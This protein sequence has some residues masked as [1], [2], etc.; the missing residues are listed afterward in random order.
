LTTGGIVPPAT[1]DVEQAQAEQRV[2]QAGPEPLIGVGEGGALTG[3]IPRLAEAVV[4]GMAGPVP[5]GALG[6]GPRIRLPRGVPAAER[7]EPTF[8]EPVPEAAGGGR[9]PAEPVGEGGAQPPAKLPPPK[10]VTYQELDDDLFKAQQT[11][12]AEMLEAQKVGAQL[13]AN[14]ITVDDLREAYH[15]RESRMTKRPLPETNQSKL[16]ESILA[17][18]DNRILQDAQWIYEHAP[19]VYKT[20]PEVPLRTAQEG[21]VHRKVV[22][23]Q[24]PGERLDPTEGDILTRSFLRGGSFSKRASGLMRRD[25]VY[26]WE[27]NQG[28]ITKIQKLGETKQ[29]AQK[30]GE[31]F[32]DQNG[33]K[34]TAR[35]PTTKELEQQLPGRKYID[36]LVANTIDNALRLGRVRR[37]I[38]ILEKWKPRLYDEGLWV[39]ESTQ[40]E[41]PKNLT[42]RIEVPQLRGHAD[43]MVASIINDIFR[44]Q[45]NDWAA[46]GD[47]INRVLVGSMFWLPIRHQLNVMAHYA[48]GRGFDW[49]YR[50]PNLIRAA[51]Q[52]YTL[53]PEYIRQLKAGAGLR[54]ASTQNEN[55]YNTLLTKLG[56]DIVKDPEW[57]KVATALGFK[58]AHDLAAGVYRWSRQSLW[59]V[60]DVFLTARIMELEKAG[61]PLLE[62]IKIA[63]QEIPN[64]R[65]PTS[66]RALRGLLNSPLIAFGR[67]GYGR[68]NALV[69]TVQNLVGPNATGEERLRALGQALILTVVGASGYTI[70]NHSLQEAQKQLKGAMGDKWGK[71]ILGDKPLEFSEIGPFSVTR[72]AAR[73]GLSYMPKSVQNA[74]V[75][76]INQKIG[77]LVGLEPEAEDWSKLLASLITASPALGLVSP[78]LEGGR[79][80]FTG[81]K[82]MDPHKRLPAEIAQGLETIGGELNP[83]GVALQ[84]MRKGLVPGVGSQFGLKQEYKPNPKAML[85]QKR[86]AAKSTARDPLQSGANKLYDSLTK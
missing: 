56:H 66:N 31:T 32:T 15:I 43:P 60:N 81:Q 4:G 76:I 34:W 63:E 37:N 79:N 68:A 72:E 40:G 62:A 58:T 55:F 57:G 21:H 12:Q 54:Y 33:V 70:A 83:L 47:A 24:R 59:R 1:T 7:V 5:G 36:D 52:V 35:Q 2:G 65:L 71:R 14:G 20:M 48:V 85:M 6:A 50:N 77:A 42:G 49:L 16:I 27:N 86:G 75:P 84:V 25:P 78:L 61:K 18:L 51:T 13:K 9:G 46:A 23:Y 8:G 28:G 53:G 10:G 74:Q 17:P 45:G 64:Y 11:S 44:S 41:I 22:G 29:A 73:Y 19:E 82:L 80:L 30:Y 39:P 26:V 3:R 67:Y 69:K 38:E